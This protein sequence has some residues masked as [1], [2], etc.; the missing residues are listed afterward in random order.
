MIKAYIYPNP[1]AIRNS[2][3]LAGSPYVSHLRTALRQYAGIN[4]LSKP[5]KYG[6]LDIFRYLFR[7]DMIV[8]NWIEDLPDKKGGYLQCLL[9]VF[10]LNFMK[11]RRKKIIWVMHNKLSHQKRNLFLKKYTF[12]LMLK[13]SDLIITHAREG[14]SYAG[15]LFRGA[16]NK[17]RFVHHPMM[18]QPVQS[19]LKYKFDIIIWGKIVP[20]KGVDK[21]LRFLK[22][23]SLLEKYRICIAGEIYPP[24]YKT[25]IVQYANQN[26]IIEDK[27]LPE[28]E[29]NCRIGESKI[30]LFTYINDSV[31]SSGALMDSLIYNRYVIGPAVGAFKDL[32]EEKVINT[33]TDYIELI[34]LIDAL[35][36]KEFD[37]ENRKV[38]INNNTW[39][40]FAGKIK[41]WLQV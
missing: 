5:T 23:Q 41:E 32:A 26:I 35:L 29:L 15:S 18:R 14:V 2:I 1:A 10:L 12:S 30:I 37:Y 4:D 6:I 38:F 13:K 39:E 20:Y 28:D 25:E 27:F 34:Q 36:V 33:Y 9:L 22:E 8:F 7:L 3:D 40:S 11:I 17:I 31:L 24:Q 16:A 21:F 19:G